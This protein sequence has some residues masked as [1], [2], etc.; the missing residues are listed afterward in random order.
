M[1]QQ[2]GL[3]IATFEMIFPIHKVLFVH[4]SLCSNFG[5][6]GPVVAEISYNN[7]TLD[8]GMFR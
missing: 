5:K 2:A 4:L 3:S 6:I 1:E 8:Y 7:G